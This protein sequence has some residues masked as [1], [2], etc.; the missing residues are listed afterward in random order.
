MEDDF[1]LDHE[2]GEYKSFFVSVFDGHHGKRAA[3]FAS[4]H[5]HETIT[6]MLYNILTLFLYIPS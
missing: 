6:S 4:K 5:L 2:F 3:Q 1:S